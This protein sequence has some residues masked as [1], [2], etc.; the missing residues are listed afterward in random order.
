[1]NQVIMVYHCQTKG[2]ITLNKDELEEFRLQKENEVVPWPFGTGPA[3]KEFLQK[4]KS[5]L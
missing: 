1:M 2:K 4:R 3:I 5:K